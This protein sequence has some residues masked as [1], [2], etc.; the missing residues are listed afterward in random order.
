MEECV[1]WILRIIVLLIFI[2]SIVFRINSDEA[3]TLDPIKD[4]YNNKIIYYVDTRTKKTYKMENDVLYY[5]EEVTN[6]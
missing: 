6:E 3:I 1:V 2:V 4:G 5:Y